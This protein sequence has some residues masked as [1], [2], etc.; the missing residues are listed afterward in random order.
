[1]AFYVINI[2]DGKTL[3]LPSMFNRGYNSMDNHL[4][5]T[6]PCNWTGEGKIILSMVEE[7]LPFSTNWQIT[8]KTDSG[9]VQCTQKLH[10]EGFSD[11]MSN[12]VVFC[13]FT[14]NGFDVEMSNQNLGKVI[15]YGVYDDKMIGWE[16]K[17]Q[18]LKFEGYETYILQDDKSYKMT[19][20]YIS[21]DQFRTQ[22][23]G[24]IWQ[25]RTA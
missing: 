5:I 1:M 15:G 10:I 13:N 22:I 3:I 12:E 8:E 16:F 20:E 18:D 25:K 7:K 9:R 6:R 19:G 4:F 14:K 24:T 23:E 2:F 11:A 17:N 21:A